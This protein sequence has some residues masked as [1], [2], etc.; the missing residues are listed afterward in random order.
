M[1]H[2]HRKL[3]SYSTVT[4]RG[5]FLFLVTL[6]HIFQIKKNVKFNPITNWNQG[7]VMPDYCNPN[8]L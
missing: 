2:L 1:V 7:L 8:L 4:K 6:P 5:L 3:P